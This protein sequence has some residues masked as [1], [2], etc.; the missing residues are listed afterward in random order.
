MQR[1]FH[2]VGLVWNILRRYLSESITG[3]IK[4]MRSLA[5]CQGAVFDVEEQYVK[6]FVDIF[7]DTKGK[8]DFEVYKCQKLPEF[9]ENQGPK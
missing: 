1:T 6:E 3:G 9:Y 2:G 8:K 7:E 5:S 4:G